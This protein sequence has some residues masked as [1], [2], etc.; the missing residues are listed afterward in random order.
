MI[1]CP[2][3]ELYTSLPLLPQLVQ[4]AAELLGSPGELPRPWLLLSEAQYIS[5]H[6]LPPSD[7]CI[8][9]HIYIYIYTHIL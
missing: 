6:I 2:P 5:C 8:Y 1:V 7:M 3:C 4:L 9:I